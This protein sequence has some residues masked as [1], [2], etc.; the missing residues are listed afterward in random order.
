MQYI[1]QGWMKVEKVLELNPSLP[2]YHEKMRNGG[3]KDSA[4]RNIYIWP[5][6]VCKTTEQ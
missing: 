1:L 2:I 4:N 3:R 6:N 5:S